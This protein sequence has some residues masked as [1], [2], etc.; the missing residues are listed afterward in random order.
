[1]KRRVAQADVETVVGLYH[2]V[3]DIFT[4]RLQ[5]QVHIQSVIAANLM[6]R[7]KRHRVDIH[8]GKVPA[9][10]ALPG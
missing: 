2:T 3:K 5:P 8:A 7:F 6:R 1:M 4:G 9:V 10:G